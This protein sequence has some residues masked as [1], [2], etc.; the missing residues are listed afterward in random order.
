MNFLVALFL[1]AAAKS[2][3]AVAQA[4]QAAQAVQAAHAAAS[5]GIL[6]DDRRFI[7]Y[8]TIAVVMAMAS[9]FAII[10][11]AYQSQIEARQDDYKDVIVVLRAIDAQG[12]SL[13]S[14]NRSILE[15]LQLILET[16]NKIPGRGVR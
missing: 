8:G 14:Q 15:K 9:A 1:Q 5:D 13:E 10:W 3:E 4:A 16:V 2:A 6:G 7:L 11:R 12:K